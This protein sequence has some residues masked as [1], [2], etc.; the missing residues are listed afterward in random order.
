MQRVWGLIKVIIATLG[1]SQSGFLLPQLVS[2]PFSLVLKKRN[3]AF[4]ME[5]SV[6][7]SPLQ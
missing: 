3:I 2:E 5:S 7:F 1:K 4:K 6:L